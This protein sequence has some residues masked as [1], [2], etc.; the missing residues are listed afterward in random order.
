[1]TQLA[2]TLQFEGTD[3][4][5]IDHEG[6][7]WLTS[8]DIARALGYRRGDSIHRIYERNQA[9]FSDEMALTVKLTLRGA[10]APIPVRIFSPRGARLIAMLARTRRAEAFRAWVLDVLD[11]TAV[12]SQGPDPAHVA[13]C[14]EAANVVASEV[15]K[16]VAGALLKQGPIK[17][18]RF[19]VRLIAG[20]PT[21]VL[22]VPTEAALVTVDEFIKG[23][24]DIDG[25][26][27]TNDQ[28]AH[29]ISAASFRLHVRAN[30]G[31]K[32]LT[33][34]D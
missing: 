26:P 30:Q 6:Q 5:L 10:V 32:S 31:R 33:K 22:P 20:E 7:R 24:A 12:I 34:P 25:I 23:I 27:I 29:L 3:L 17:Y 4:T 2:E 8:T 21:V 19:L 1:M 13:H 28:L 11:S 15:Q 9:E 18:G 14:W 16:T